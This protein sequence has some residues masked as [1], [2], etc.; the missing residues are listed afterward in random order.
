[1]IM[2][3]PMMLITTLDVIVRAVWSRTIPGAIE[4][5]SYM[6]AVFVLL[7]IAY[8]QQV[9]GH[10]SIS[11]LTSRLPAKVSAFLNVVTTL[12][13]VLIIAIVVWQGWVVGMEEKSV[14]DMLRVP[15]LPFRML[16]PLGGLFLLF[17]L[18]FDLVDDVKKIVR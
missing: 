1:M 5:S 2:L 8:V 15:Q 10:V 16:V 4:L 3:I 13:S 18:L 12:L 6:L 14:S 11:M 7:G 17:E 9:K